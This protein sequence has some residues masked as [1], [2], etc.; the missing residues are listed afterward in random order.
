MFRG[1]NGLVVLGF[2]MLGSYRLSTLAAYDMFA[3]LAR[4]DHTYGAA[5]V[6]AEIYDGATK[7][8]DVD[9]HLWLRAASVVK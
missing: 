2:N 8:G 1:S 4:L 5:S 9:V 6:A 7:V 3:K